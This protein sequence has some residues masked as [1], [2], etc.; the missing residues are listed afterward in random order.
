M[1]LASVSGVFDRDLARQG[2]E[3]AVADF[4]LDRVGTQV[5]ALESGGDVLGLRSQTSAKHLPVVGVVQEGLLAADALDL[6]TGVQ[7]AVIPPEGK[8]L[9]F[10]PKRANQGAQVA[11]IILQIAYRLDARP[12][13]ASLGYLAHA[14]KCTHRQRAQE[15]H[16]LALG[17]QR[18]PVR[19]LVVAGDLGQ[20]L[21]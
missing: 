20:Q 14:V 4:D 12:G 16:L 7:A 18:Q 2:R 15:L 3:I 19:L 11:R 8:L 5:A 1:S 17:N 10:R 6:V 21:V 13:S 9:Q